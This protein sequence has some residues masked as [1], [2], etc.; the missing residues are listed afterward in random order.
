T[1]SAKLSEKLSIEL[2]EN[3]SYEL[4]KDVIIVTSRDV[5]DKDQANVAAGLM[6]KL[7][8]KSFAENLADHEAVWKKRW[9]KSDVV[10][11]GDDAAQ[12]G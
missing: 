9:D 5:K 11:A 2:A 4:E 3:E 10:I 7:Q 1:E 12:Q 6:K 8:S